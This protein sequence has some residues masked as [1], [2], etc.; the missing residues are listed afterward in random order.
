MQRSRSLVLSSE[1]AAQ[2]A[3]LYQEMEAAYD[4]VAS[5]LGFSCQG[6]PDNCCDS[7][8]QHHT[9]IEWSYLWQGLRSLDADTLE[10]VERR[11]RTCLLDCER[12]LARGQRPQAMCPLNVEGLCSL[13][14]HRLMICRLHGVPGRLTL[15]DGRV[16]EFGGCHRCRDLELAASSSAVLD[17]T[18]FLHRLAA[19]EKELLLGLGRPVPRVR[20]TIAQMIVRGEPY[21]VTGQPICGGTG[22]LA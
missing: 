18:P 10:A 8:F 4:A 6:C 20:L 1:L 17:R 22:P 3:A 13:Y 12:Q 21:L 5:Q 11:A 19:L 9:Y 14:S 16:E 15:P 2:L 7:H